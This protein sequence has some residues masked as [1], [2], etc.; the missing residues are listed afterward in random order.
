MTADTRA[1]ALPHVE[2][3]DP[4]GHMSQGVNTALL[5]MLLFIGSEVMF[6]AGLFGAY[7]N[8]RATAIALGQAWPP[9]G[10]EQVIEPGL[11]PI[12][13]TTLLILSSFTMQ[14]GV[15][16][17][18]RGDRTGMN[19]ALM[20]TLFLGIVFLGMQVYDYFELV[21]HYGFGINSGIYGS[22]FYTMT[23]F[24]GAHVFGGVVGIAIILM[25]GLAGQFS[26]KHH[27]AVEAVSAYWHFVDIVW[28]GL[29]FVLYF[30]K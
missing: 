5:G 7:F 3:D 15:W 29:F 25:R 4:G 11:I 26:A 14:W 30:L 19:R 6:F 12:V 23:G 9:E 18:R 24:H 1:V 2:E 27:I 28:I 16:R 21:T 8:T 22:L 13:A 10:L 20:L 17:I